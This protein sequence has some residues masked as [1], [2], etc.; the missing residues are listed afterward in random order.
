MPNKHYAL[1]VNDPEKVHRHLLNVNRAHHLKRFSEVHGREPK[2]H[3]RN[4][5]EQ[6]IRQGHPDPPPKDSLH[7]EMESLD[8]PDGLPNCRNC[9]DPQHAEACIAAG[10]CPHCGTQHG[11]TP[12]RL[13]AE[14]GYHLLELE[15]EQADAAKNHRHGHSMWDEKT[16]R[17]VA[18]EKIDPSSAPQAL[19]TDH[20]DAIVE[21][22]AAK[23]KK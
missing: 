23:L 1:V 3:E 19:T 18:R 2:P 16:R 20:I 9:G 10:H 22:L 4:K 11:M 7:T 15:G 21:R 17:F 12:Q 8:C 5:I 13:L 6:H 14:G